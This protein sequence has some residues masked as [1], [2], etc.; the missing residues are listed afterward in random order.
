MYTACLETN[1]MWKF[2]P[3]WFVEM[4]PSGG[5]LRPALL[6][7]QKSAG[8][9]EAAQCPKGSCGVW[10]EQIFA[11][12]WNWGDFLFHT[13]TCYWIFINRSWNYPH[14][15]LKDIISILNMRKQ[16]KCTQRG[17][18]PLSPYSN[19]WP[20]FRWDK[21]V[22]FEHLSNGRQSRCPREGL[23]FILVARPS[24]IHQVFISWCAVVQHVWVLH[25]SAP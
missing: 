19:R 2:S 5:N 15:T 22:C 16:H 12:T 13:I 14:G 6:S 24:K 21:C 1:G 7:T 23:P 20:H 10:V 9:G 3:F 11:V 17:S 8:M 4:L 18:G 25:C